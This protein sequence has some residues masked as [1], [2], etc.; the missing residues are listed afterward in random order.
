MDSKP[1][2]SIEFYN[3]TTSKLVLWLEP[4]CEELD[5]LSDT[6]Y[7]LESE[8]AEYRLEITADSIIL[9]NQRGF[10]PKIL[11]RPYSKDFNNPTPWE[12]VVNYS[13]V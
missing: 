12:V 3:R 4:Y 5:L 13:D 1:T 8:E 10:A 11:K 6:E 9:Y 7:R 2:T